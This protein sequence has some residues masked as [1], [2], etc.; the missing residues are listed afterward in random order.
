MKSVNWEWCTKLIWWVIQTIQLHS[1]CPVYLAVTRNS[2][3]MFNPTDFNSFFC[4]FC[5]LILER[6]KKRRKKNFSGSIS[7]VELFFPRFRMFFIH[8]TIAILF[9]MFELYSNSIHSRI[10]YIDILNS[11]LFPFPRT[12]I[13]LFRLLFFFSSLS[14]DAFFDFWCFHQRVCAFEQIRINVCAILNCIGSL[15][16]VLNSISSNVSNVVQPFR[17]VDPNEK[18]KGTEKQRN[19]T[20][21]S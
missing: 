2:V 8:S 11:M 1:M 15:W 4:F 5:S 9:T 12:Q 21:A 13:D 3:Q 16:I 18:G 6:K 19:V 7:T 14:F 10:R 20:T 17:I